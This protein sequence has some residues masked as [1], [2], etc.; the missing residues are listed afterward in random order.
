MPFPELGHVSRALTSKSPRVQKVLLGIGGLTSENAVAMWKA[1]EASDDIAVPTR[2]E[3]V[4]GT[5]R[6]VELNGHILI[7]QILRMRERQIEEETKIRR[8]RS[9]ISG[10]DCYSGDT[11]GVGVGRIHA[12]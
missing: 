8:H 3:L 7:G 6:L 5:K 10:S 9:I 2:V 11:A 12:R 4:A 1:T